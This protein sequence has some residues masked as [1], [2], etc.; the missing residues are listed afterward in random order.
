MSLNPLEPTGQ[1]LLRRL[2][3]SSERCHEFD[4]MAD[5][6][7]YMAIQRA[8]ILVKTGGYVF[9][10]WCDNSECPDKSHA[11]QSFEGPATCNTCGGTIELRKMY[12]KVLTH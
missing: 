9:E 10:G 5:A 11:I 4:T 6:M 8:A 1:E 2:F 12:E 7:Q 3:P